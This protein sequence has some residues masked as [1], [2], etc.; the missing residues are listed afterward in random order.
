MK[1]HRLTALLIISL[2]FELGISSCSKC[3]DASACNFGD[4]G[5]CDFVKCDNASNFD[6][7]MLA[8]YEH[9][10]NGEPI[11]SVDAETSYDTINL[12]ENPILTED[13]GR[14]S[15]TYQ[16]VT[17]KDGRKVFAIDSLLTERE[18]NDNWIIDDENKLAR[19]YSKSLD[20]LLVLDVSSSLG[21]NL[22]LLKANAKA[23]ISNLLDNN[24]DARIGIFKFSRGSVYQELTS[25]E[26]D[27]HEFIDANSTFKSSDIGS[28]EIEGRS[29]TALYETINEAIDVLNLSEAKGKG[30]VTFTDGI[31]NFQFDPDFFDDS[32][33]KEKLDESNI[34]SY[35]IG[36][37]ANVGSVDQVSLE[38][39]AINGDFSF[40]SNEEELNEVF[41]RF[42]NSVLAFYDLTFETNNAEFNGT[43]E[44][45][46][47]FGLKEV[48]N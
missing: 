19:S 33:I 38:E 5:D 24:P 8:T 9:P 45:R 4:K 6:A 16:V 48:S 46:F 18:N 47:L 15:F 27:L 32:I 28:Y 3:E 22:D 10:R 41:L 1:F 42:S 25:S 7:Q 11:L 2:F 14:I 13:N 34:S 20:I 40:P 12:D 44:Y 31:S 21:D 30:I 17:F 26:D 35:T 37:E 23:F 29:E 36:F 43:I 39:I